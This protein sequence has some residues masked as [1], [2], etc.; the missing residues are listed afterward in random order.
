MDVHLSSA[1]IG[2]VYR[3]WVLLFFICLLFIIHLLCWKLLF[4]YFCR[5]KAHSSGVIRGRTQRWGHGPRRATGTAR[6]FLTAE[7]GRGDGSRVLQHRQVSGADCRGIWWRPSAQPRPTQ[8]L[9]SIL[10]VSFGVLHG[11]WDISFSPNPWTEPGI[12][13]S[14]VL[15]H[16][17][18]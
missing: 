8:G 14:S 2:S 18:A 4:F 10:A 1:C 17:L 7:G 5:F 9:G 13:P 3:K 12:C 16:V 6:C 15:K 11:R